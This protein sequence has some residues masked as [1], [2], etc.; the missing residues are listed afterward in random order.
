MTEAIALLA[1]LTP[2]GAILTIAAVL[3]VGLTQAAKQQRWTKQRTQ[4]VA[5]AI[6]AVLGALA[7]LVLGLIA[8]VPESVIEAVSAVLLSIA[9]VLVLARVLYGALGYAIP[10]G[11]TPEPSVSELARAQYRIAKDATEAR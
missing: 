9:A 6:S 5:L 7:A 3:S 8:G 2:I 1:D 11:T 4:L 10:D